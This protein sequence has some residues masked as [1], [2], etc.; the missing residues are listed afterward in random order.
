MYIVKKQP[1][2]PGRR[3]LKDLIG[4]KFSGHFRVQ[5][6]RHCFE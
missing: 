5:S 1:V 4:D 3:A 2:Q 6:W